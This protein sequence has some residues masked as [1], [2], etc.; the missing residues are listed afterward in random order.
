MALS[1]TC[2]QADFM[3]PFLL[4]SRHLNHDFILF[5][6]TFSYSS[7]PS[8]HTHSLDQSLK[9]SHWWSSQTQKR[10][11]RMIPS[12]QSTKGARLTWGVWSQKHHG[13]CIYLYLYPTARKRFQ[14]HPSTAPSDLNCHLHSSAHTR[15]EVAVSPPK[16]GNTFSHRSPLPSW[17][18][19]SS[20]TMEVGRGEGDG[21][22]PSQGPGR[23]PVLPT[24]PQWRV[25][26]LVPML[27]LHTGAPS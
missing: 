23:R 24:G 26:L 19:S 20:G 22:P 13:L 16:K 2:L 27:A 15:Q 1:K 21:D 12:P 7:G 4:G 10:I 6:V 9:M 5:L 25:S 11:C 14:N 8:H 3:F 17:H 18:A